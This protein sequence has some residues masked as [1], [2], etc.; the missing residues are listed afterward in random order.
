MA[1]LPAGSVTPASLGAQTRAA[2]GA[3][4][5]SPLIRRPEASGAASGAPH[6]GKAI[7]GNDRSRCARRASCAGH[8]VSCDVAS[9]PS[10]CQPMLTLV[11][12][13]T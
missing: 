3:A 4:A 9:T 7:S 13:A 5:G 11:P 10:D 6:P 8:D 12:T 1:T 2:S